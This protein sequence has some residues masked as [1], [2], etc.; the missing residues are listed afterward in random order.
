M[1]FGP[2]TMIYFLLGILQF[3]Q[4]KPRLEITVCIWGLCVGSSL[5][6]LLDFGAVRSGLI[7]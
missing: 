2:D 7:S 5:Y 6:S 4:D 3:L 1:P